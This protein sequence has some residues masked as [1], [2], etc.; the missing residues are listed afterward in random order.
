VFKVVFYRYN[1]FTPS[2]CSQNMHTSLRLCLESHATSGLKLM[3]ISATK[4]LETSTKRKIK[5]P[6]WPLEVK[7]SPLK[8]CI[9]RDWVYIP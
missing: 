1:L 9:L 3:R 6:L 5:H 8:L 2:S 7:K 4:F